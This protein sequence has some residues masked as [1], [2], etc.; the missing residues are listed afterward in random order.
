S[1]MLIGMQLISFAIASKKIG[2]L[3]GYLSPPRQWHHLYSISVERVLQI[4][5]LPIL[6]GL[7]GTGSITLDWIS[8]DFSDIKEPSTLRQFVFF[9]MTLIA[10]IQIACTGFIL[11]VVEASAGG[12]R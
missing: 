4:S 1:F 2:V 5:L 11:A 7:W 10:G 8:S 6:I 3:H 12:K 9:T